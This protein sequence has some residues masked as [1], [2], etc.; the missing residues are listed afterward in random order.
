MQ[1]AKDRDCI[2]LFMEMRLGKTLTAIRWASQSFRVLVIAPNE[3]HKGW[4]EELEKERI[5]CASLSGSVKKRFADAKD[6]SP[7]KWCLI[8]PEGV[9]VWPEVFSTGLFD[10]CILD[11]SVVI[12]NPGTKTSR[13]FF[14]NRNCIKRKALLSGLPSPNNALD[15]IN[16]FIWLKGSFMGYT[17]PWSARDALTVDGPFNQPILKRGMLKRIKQ[18]VDKNAFCK[19]QKEAGF[20][21]KKKF[22]LVKFGLNESQKAQVRTAQED[23]QIA[24][25]LA[26][27]SI[28]IHTWLRRISGGFTL[29]DQDEGW[30][31]TN[32]AK[33]KYILKL[34][35]SGTRFIVWCSYTEEVKEIYKALLKEGIRAEEITG[36]VKT[37][38]REITLDLFEKKH[39]QVLVMQVSCGKYGLTLKDIDDAV[40]YSL[41]VSPNQWAQSKERI[42]LEEKKAVRYHILICK[43]TG[44][45]ELYH[46]LKH[47]SV[48]SKAIVTKLFAKDKQ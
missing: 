30:Q 31:L 3:T 26:K 7:E 20:K 37:G 17:E 14:K 45:E 25:A 29:F 46:S 5:D 32:R 35:S 13:L 4:K 38:I 8:N 40:Y 23:W 28:V 33:I 1:Y 10:V 34:A 47:G 43:D 41:P 2:A 12:K 42:V 15:L 44:E 19:T 48:S 24:D 6:Y 27:H 18:W 22:K 11:E 36:K 9:R 21:V 39:L 16:Q